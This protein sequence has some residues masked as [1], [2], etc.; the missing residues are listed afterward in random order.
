MLQRPTVL[1]FPTRDHVSRQRETRDFLSAL[2]FAV[3]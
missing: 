1:R 3:A 2:Y